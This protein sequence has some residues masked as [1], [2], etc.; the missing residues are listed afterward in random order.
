MEKQVNTA[1]LNING[2]TLDVSGGTLN[3]SDEIIVGAVADGT[4][5]NWGTSI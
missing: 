2:G 3:V 5:L 4:L 1:A